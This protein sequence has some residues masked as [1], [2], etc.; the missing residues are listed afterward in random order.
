MQTK[1]KSYMVNRDDRGG[2]IGVVNSGEWR[3]VNYVTT[4]QGAV[5]GNHYHKRCRELVFVIEGRVHVTLSN[6]RAS[7]ERR[8]LTLV[9]GEGVVLDPYTLHAMTY[10]EDTTQISLLD[11]P[12]DPNHPDLHT[13]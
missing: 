4:K 13:V 9:S 5:R 3:E 10:E 2:M 7:D 6:A 8:Q 11:H 1:V 12:F